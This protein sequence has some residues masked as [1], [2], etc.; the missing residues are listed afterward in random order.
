M[1]LFSTRPLPR[2]LLAPRFW[3]T[4]LAMGLLRALCLL[5]YRVQLA[6][7]RR[8]GRLALR[9]ARRRRRIA[10]I[11]LELCFPELSMPERRELLRR[12]FEA[13]GISL[14]EISM[15][16]WAP[17][18]KLKPLCHMEGLEYVQRGL[19]AGNGVILLSAHFLPMDLGARLLLPHQRFN[20]MYR[21]H[22]NPVI[23][24]VMAGSRELHVEQAI[25]SKSIKQAIRTLKANRVLWYAPDQN[26]TPRE[27][28]FADFFGIPAST[29][30]GTARLARV[31]GAAVVPYHAVRRADGSGY[32]L[33]F[34]PA[35][36]DFPSDNLVADTQRINDRIEGWARRD[37]EQYLWVHRR[38]RHRPDPSETRLYD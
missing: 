1:A 19:E 11:N 5:P 27:A 4:W 25:P 7:G 16:W 37:P 15:S 32:D 12:H 9:L 33:L 13:L 14:F 29:N 38:F 3:T 22:K 6:L 24:W 35:L 17:D 2:P 36:D 34:E 8:V 26:T 10:E 31:T 30:S 28:V 18:S 20:A 23:E 21:S